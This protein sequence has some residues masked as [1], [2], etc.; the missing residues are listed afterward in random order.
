VSRSDNIPSSVR[1]RTG[2][3]NEWRYSSIEKAGKL[4]DRN[5]SDSIAYACESVAELVD[6]IEKVLEREDLTHEQRREIAETLST[7]TL[8]FD[9]PEL[10]VDVGV[11]R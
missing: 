4:F 11:D 8:S 6:G 2:E 3:G 5:R 1:I 7:R 10:E 9:I